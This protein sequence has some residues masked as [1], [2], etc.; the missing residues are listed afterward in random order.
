PPPLP[1]E[2]R[3]VG[4]LVAETI[5][6]YGRRF[7]PSLALGLSLAAVNQASAG[8]RALEQALIVCAGAPLLT[9][10]LIGGSALASGV[11]VE[12]RRLWTAFAGG[13]LVFL[14][15]PWLAL[16][17]VLPAVA[18]L[19]FF[20][21]YVPAVVVEHLGLRTGIRR[22]VALAR[23][24]YVHALGSLATLLIVFV[25]SRVVLVLLLH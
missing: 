24:D 12:R 14:P 25:L 15:A 18:W 4:Q 11:S 13:V 8:H 1:P 21:M 6:L 23:A 10:S 20:G 9:L 3:T 16:G 7:W 19:A 5:K 17:Y 2:T 22:A